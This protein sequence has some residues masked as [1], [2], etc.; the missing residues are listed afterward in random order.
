MKGD[1]ESRQIRRLPFDSSDTFAPSIQASRMGRNNV[2]RS[3]DRGYIAS[4]IV[5]KLADNTNASW[6]SAS[7][8]MIVSTP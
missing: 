1:D 4:K 3:G 7:G 8:S 6:I 2:P 5:R